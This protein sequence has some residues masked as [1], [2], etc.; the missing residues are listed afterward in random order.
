MARFF[1]QHDAAQYDGS[2]AEAVAELRHWLAQGW[3]ATEPEGSN[4][5]PVN[6]A[7]MQALIREWV[8]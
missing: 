3:A 4:T 5:E 2:E 1:E 8:L 6:A 7:Q